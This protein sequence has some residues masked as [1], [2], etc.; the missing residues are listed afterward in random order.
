MPK[1]SI[2][3]N[4]LGIITKSPLSGRFASKHSLK[5]NNLPTTKKS[6]QPVYDLSRASDS[7][8]RKFMAPVDETGMQRDRCTLTPPDVDIQTR[9]HNICVLDLCPV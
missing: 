5:A 4:G 2:S 8:H 7:F 6:K 3:L 1:I 9:A